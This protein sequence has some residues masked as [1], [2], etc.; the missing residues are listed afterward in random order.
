MSERKSAMRDMT[1]A[2]RRSFLGRSLAMLVAAGAAS[3]TTPAP[4]RQAST[5]PPASASTL[6]WF[7]GFRA[8]RVNA[9]GITINGVMGGSGPPVL[10]MHGWP[11]THVEWHRVAPMLAQHFTV[12]ATDLRG[13]GDSTKPADGTNHDGY[14]KRAMARDQVEVMRQLGFERFAA[15]GHDRGGRVGHRMALD[16]P[17]TVT[18]LAVLDIVP[19]YK[20]YSTVSKDLA[21]F[22]YHWFF[23]IQPAPLP[24]TLLGS[25]AE[26]FLRTWAFRGSVPSVITDEA[27]AEYLRW[28]RDPTTL[29]A[30]C[31]DYRAAATIDLEHDKGD[32]ESK[33]QCPLLTLWGGRGVMQRLYDVV[34]T[35]KERAADVRGK[36]LPG[37]H[38]LPEQLSGEVYAELKAFLL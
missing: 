32:L 2:G 34:A 16:Y 12:V 25:N 9:T 7:P 1:P 4:G 22:Y 29:H 33:I 24:E 11:Q 20:L 18:K 13:Y 38:W 26:F 6:R 3:T 27:F 21:T 31:E 28:F 19:T 5:Q 36:A 30:M 37:G 35:W 23:L 14:S 17:N 15:V 10:L 8:I